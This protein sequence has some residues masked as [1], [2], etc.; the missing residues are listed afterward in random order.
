MIILN[1][2]LNNLIIYYLYL[3]NNNMNHYIWEGKHIYFYDYYMN[4]HRNNNSLF[5][6]N[7]HVLVTSRYQKINKNSIS[8][9]WI[10]T[11]VYFQ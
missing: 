1:M 5:I 10:G 4:N 7:Q 9:Q 11:H 2:D 8:S 3:I 6:N